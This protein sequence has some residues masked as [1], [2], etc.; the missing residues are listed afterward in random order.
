MELLILNT[1]LESDS[2]ID[3]YKSLIWTDRYSS[4]GDFEVYTSA[5]IN[6]LRQVKKG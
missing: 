2:I 6:V 3:T 4:Y 1:K 5:T